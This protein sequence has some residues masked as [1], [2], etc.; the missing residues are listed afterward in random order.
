MYEGFYP[1]RPKDYVEQ[2]QGQLQRL[3]AAV[4]VGIEVGFHLCYGSP[5]DEHIVQPKDTG[6][7]VEILNALFARASRPIEFVHLPVP[8]QRT[9]EAYFAPLQKLALQPSCELIVGLIHEGDAAGNHARL[10]AA[11]KFARI[12]GIGTECGWGRKSPERLPGVL[13]AHQAA[14]VTAQP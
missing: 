11:R 3:A 5:R 9:D 10:A 2:I 8:R 12:A 4:S 13:A 6:V 1:E 7:M 14:G